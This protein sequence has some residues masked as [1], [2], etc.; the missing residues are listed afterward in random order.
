MIK[1]K[2]IQLLYSAT[3]FH[4][5]FVFDP[6]GMVRNE[7][8]EITE[9][10]HDGYLYQIFEGGCFSTNIGLATAWKDKRTLSKIW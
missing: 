3:D 5:L 7:I 9:P 6:T 4:V 10:W 2:N 8:E 1:R